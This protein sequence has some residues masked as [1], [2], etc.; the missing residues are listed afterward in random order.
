V[1]DES[2]DDGLKP[3]TLYAKYAN[4]SVESPAVGSW[5][6]KP[7]FLIESNLNAFLCTAAGRPL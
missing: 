6:A 1:G 7:Y 4:V 3:S 5:D 2:H